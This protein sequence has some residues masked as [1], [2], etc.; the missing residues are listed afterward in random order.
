MSVFILVS[1]G[2]IQRS[3]GICGQDQH[4]M[5]KECANRW[6]E[7]MQKEGKPANCP[8]C[9]GAP[10]GQGQK[11]GF[12]LV[13]YQIASEMFKP[14]DHKYI[15]EQLE[16]FHPENERHQESPIQL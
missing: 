13:F 12:A 15:I 5:H 7:Q 3:N 16:S 11:E 1:N 9:R 8:T 14:Y 6:I 10:V 4:V 2:D